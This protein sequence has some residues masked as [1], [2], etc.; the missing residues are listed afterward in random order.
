IAI[1][2]AGIA[3]QGK[4]FAYHYGATLPLVAFIAGI[5]LY[6]LWMRCLQGGVGGILAF[7]SFVIVAALM[8]YPVGDLPQSV[9]ERARI[10]IAYLLDR[11]PFED[12]PAM[13]RELAYVADF[14]LDADRRV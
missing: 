4:F 11:P 12:R 5:G 8:R 3:M 10:R 14:N 1:E 13:D 2:L 7:F 6:K 9:W